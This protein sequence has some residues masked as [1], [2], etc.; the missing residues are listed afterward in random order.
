MAPTGSSYGNG[1]P[2]EQ[3]VTQTAGGTGRLTTAAE[4]C[5]RRRRARSGE[6]IG[7]GERRTRASVM[8]GQNV[9][10]LAYQWAHL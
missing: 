8:V 3:Q 2:E 4:D 1:V 9:L 10:A 6:G 5:G 7:G